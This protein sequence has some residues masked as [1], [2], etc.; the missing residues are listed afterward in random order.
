MNTLSP[1]GRTR[2]RRHSERGRADRQDLYDVL[3]A[4]LICHLGVVIDDVP[5]VL[6]TGYGRDGDT[7]YL[8]GSTGAR[9]LMAAAEDV[10]VC[11]AVT[12]VDGIVMARSVFNHSMNY[13]SA[14][15]Y[16]RPVSMVSD[17]EKLAGLRAVVDH[18]APG[19]W[20]VL[21]PTNRKELAATSVLALSLAEAS[22]KIR[23]GP[24]ADEEDAPGVW[25]GVLPVRQVF[26]PPVPDPELPGGIAVPAHVAARVT[27]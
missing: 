22:V 4:G 27:R 26:E 10:E 15:V 2:I 9:S 11:V 7:L 18:L 25:S 24:S 5:H 20:D 14:M 16:G 12:L 19:Q 21:R 6:P 8:H 17:E 1:T 23:T 3:D 13:R